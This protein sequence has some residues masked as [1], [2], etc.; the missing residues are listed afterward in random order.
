[1]STKIWRRANNVISLTRNRD[2]FFRWRNKSHS[3]NRCH[4]EIRENPSDEAVNQCICKHLNPRSYVN[5]KRL[6]FESSDIGLQ[7]WTKANLSLTINSTSYSQNIYYEY[8]ASFQ[9]LFTCKYQTL[10]VQDS[11]NIMVMPMV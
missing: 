2:L 1:M 11:E 5:T 10:P 3:K 6:L 8:S 7:D 4:P 9:W